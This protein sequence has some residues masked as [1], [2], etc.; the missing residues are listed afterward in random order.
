MDGLFYLG[1]NLINL[2]HHIKL[3]ISNWPNTGFL[4]K[5]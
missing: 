2:Y 3:P 1:I 5:S 4:S